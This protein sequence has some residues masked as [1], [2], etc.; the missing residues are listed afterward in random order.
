MTI[1]EDIGGKGI[2]IDMG[3]AQQ[4]EGRNR[5]QEWEDLTTIAYLT[6]LAQIW[7]IF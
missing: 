7:R 2:N 6:S 5:E 1:L 4:Q 3:D